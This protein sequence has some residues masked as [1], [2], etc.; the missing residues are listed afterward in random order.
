MNIYIFVLSVM[1]ANST[2][3]AELS[4]IPKNNSSALG[5]QVLYFK[6]FYRDVKELY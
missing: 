4:N 5:S 2:Y 1:C 6:I 3:A